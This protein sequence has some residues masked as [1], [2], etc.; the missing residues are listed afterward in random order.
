MTL[1]GSPLQR[2]ALVLAILSALGVTVYLLVPLRADI[3]VLIP[4]RQS[5]DLEFL[6]RSI[7]EG[8]ANR[9]VVLGLEPEQGSEPL[10]RPGA[11][12][13]AY[14]AELQELGLFEQVTNGEV[15]LDDTALE[16]FFLHRYHLNPPLEVDWYSPP[17]LRRALEGLIRRLQGLSEVIVKPIMAADPTLRT[18]EIANHW[19]TSSRGIAKR[20][21]VWTD[22]SGRRIL[23]LTR[24]GGT[25]FD[26]PQQEAAIAAMRAAAA[27]LHPEFGNL[28]LRLTGP[29][30][31]AVESH[32]RAESE[33][34][35][36]MYLSVPLVAGL[37]LL[38]F[39]R[40]AVLPFSVVPLASG[41]LAGTLSVALTFGFVHVTTL[42]FG[43]A[44][45]GVAVDYPLHL[46]TRLRLGR[47]SIEAAR[48]IWP[49]LL[50]G[51][52][53]TVFGFLPLAL[54]SF[55]GIAQLGVFTVSGLAVAAAT[56][57][58]VLP[59]F[60]AVPSGSEQA[61]THRVLVLGHA[62]LGRWRILALLLGLSAIGL[63]G[64]RGQGIWQSDLANLS[65]VPKDMRAED[66]LLRRDL[67]AA[68]P[69][70]LLTVGGAT[71]EQVLQRSEALIP[72]L[73]ALQDEGVLE[74][75]ELAARYLPS[76]ATQRARLTRLPGEPALRAN[77]VEAQEGLPFKPGIFEDFLRAVT[78]ARTTG[79]IEIQDLA[80]SELRLRLESLL[81]RNGNDYQGLVQLR[82]LDDPEALLSRLR[83]AALPGV[84]F[85]DVKQSLQDLMEGYRVE[86]L[87][88]AALG[89]VLAF[90]LLI[91]G[92]RSVKAIIEVAVPVLLSVAITA[93]IVTQVSGGLS[94]FHLLALLM[95]G[96]LG[97][98]YAVFL[99]HT[100]MPDGED[101]GEA[102]ASL[103][104]VCICA[105]TSFS[106]FGVLAT[107][108]IPVLSQIGSTVAIGTVLSL[109]LS[110]VF[111]GAS[112]RNKS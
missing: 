13:R 43:A 90:I 71:V 64:T 4:E 101:N 39:R 79:P 15:A 33:S 1:P 19:A 21:G 47:T 75:I 28:R 37:L 70:Y 10:N 35:R 29:S 38:F 27:R 59:H 42:G 44:L 41:F 112:A 67:S 51:S 107:A 65:P 92:L 18:L 54:S 8:P 69:R 97:I 98:D 110:L 76:M 80:A 49:A 60:I 52:L 34:R 66:R 72:H 25:S 89:A 32:R 91:F 56:T 16:T 30:V 74:G 17:N 106:V 48:R 95:V 11:L 94:I 93:A 24:L 26:F 40:P 105:A 85:L 87:N 81:I 22:G 86:T 68:N 96:G 62:F 82:S 100:E 12:S 73:H 102:A 55:P 2:L 57:R 77:L 36:L 83:S 84:R 109:V 104:A 50:L 5:A 103:R 88:W 7:R 14:K 3:S 31:I 58:W 9:V 53:T 6:F 111:S 23:L 20:Q 99:R 45:I 78:E 63:L 61:K 46:L 108:A